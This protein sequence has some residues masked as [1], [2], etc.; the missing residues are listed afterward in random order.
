MQEKGLFRAVSGAIA[1]AFTRHSKQ[2][3]PAEEEFTP[4][5]ATEL[6]VYCLEQYLEPLREMLCS[7]NLP[8]KF[9]IHESVA[10]VAKIRK[11]LQHRRIFHKC[12]EEKE[13]DPN[14]LK[15]VRMCLNRLLIYIKSMFN[16]QDN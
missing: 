6:S 11:C 12:A 10:E 8:N 3:S 16:I 14:K 1:S 4:L 15:E 13:I 2:D 7:G 5:R 9:D